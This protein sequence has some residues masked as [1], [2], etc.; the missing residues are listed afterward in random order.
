MQLSHGS[1]DCCPEAPSAVCMTNSTAQ[2]CQG[3]PKTLLVVSLFDG[4]GAVWQALKETAFDVI[5]FSFEVDP[6]CT[7]VSKHNFPNLRQCGDA[8]SITWQWLQSV[9]AKHC[10]DFC[11]LAGSCPCQQL[12]SLSGPALGLAGKSSQAFWTFAQ[13]RIC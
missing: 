13:A 3:K 6:F 7:A 12:S 10:P 2:S 11:L 4:I 1:R 8:T 5:P 9:V